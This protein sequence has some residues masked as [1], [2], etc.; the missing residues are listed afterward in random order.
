MTSSWKPLYSF[1][2][3]VQNK[4]FKQQILMRVHLILCFSILLCVFFSELVREDTPPAHYEIGHLRYKTYAL[5][6][7]VLW[8]NAQ[9][10]RIPVACLEI[11]GGVTL[12][13]TYVLASD[14]NANYLARACFDVLAFAR[15]CVCA[16]LRLCVRLHVRDLVIEFG[17]RLC[18]HDQRK[19]TSIFKSYKLFL[20][21]VFFHVTVF[22]SISISPCQTFL[23]IQDSPS[24]YFNHDSIMGFLCDFLGT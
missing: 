16:F 4:I 5:H 19:W 7:T 3:I 24:S 6:V 18:D 13:R 22:V 15:S 10:V 23:I 21:C 9:T 12:M 11:V 8:V 1:V 20:L 2:S 17:T 14:T